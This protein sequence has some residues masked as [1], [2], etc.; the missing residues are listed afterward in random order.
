MK[1][2]IVQL[3]LLI[4]CQQ[5]AA[6]Q[7]GTRNFIDPN[8]PG[9]EPKL[10]ADGVVSDGL[11]NRDMAISPDGKEIF[12]TVQ[13][14][15]AGISVIMHSSYTASGWTKPEVTAFSGVWADLEPAFSPDGQ[16]LYFVSNRPI[17]DTGKA[18]DF[19][20]WYLVKT[21]GEWKKIAHLPAPV[22]TEKDE[23][24]PSI[25][26]NGNLYFTR[27]MEG[28]KED[29]VYCVWER[30]KYKEAQSLSDAVNSKGFE[31]NACVDPDEK[32][33]LFTAYGRKEDLGRGDLYISR[34]DQSGQWQTA[35]HL[36]IN[37]AAID[38]CPYVSP[39]GKYL[40]FTSARAIKRT[41]GKGRL[42]YNDL[43]KMLAQSGN[44]LDDIYWVLFSE[45]LE[46]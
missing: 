10:F 35:K 12:Y 36:H 34:R 38:Y 22:N 45:V 7:A 27:E 26:R 21:N 23:Y 4:G 33:I 16:R 46:E 9:K 14:N 20:I 39:D 13:H 11:S 3:F 24:Y 8:P 6:Q 43:K 30:G 2:Y 28:K 15:P 17:T 31:F 18:K 29:I 37:S 25:A 19:D 32:F 5:I 44:G 40:F 42:Q 41:V 1:K